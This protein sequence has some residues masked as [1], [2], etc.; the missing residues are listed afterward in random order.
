MNYPV[1]SF[2]AFLNAANGP[3]L[4]ADMFSGA[5]GISGGLGNDALNGFA[6]LDTLAGGK[7]DDSISGGTGNDVLVGDDGND[8]LDGGVGNDTMDGG[9]GA[10][11]MTGGAGDDLYGVDS[12]SDVVTELSGDGHDT[13][14]SSIDYELGTNLE[15]LVLLAGATLGTGNDTDNFILGNSGINGLFGGAGNDTLDGGAGM[16]LLVGG[17][18][19]DSYFVDQ[20]LDGVLEGAGGGI[21]TVSS[22]VTY[23]LGGNIENLALLGT[24]AINGNGN[25]LANLTIGN[26]GA[27]RLRGVG[28]ADTLDGGLGADT[29]T[30]GAGR[31]VFLRHGIGEGQDIVTDFTTG[32]S[33][34]LADISDMLIG[35][36]AGSSAIGDFVQ[37]LQSGGNTILQVDADGA[38]NGSSFTSVFELSGVTTTVND[39][40]ANGNLALA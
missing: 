26:D 33:G 31:D 16:D 32:G 14:Q 40:V 27:N 28:G 5:D 3:G 20:A 11:S 18:G 7:G 25:G 29:L 15:D 17:A 35:Y 1:T 2:L 6:G 22:L 39:L 21:D 19:N 12:K 24:A 8:T 34:D 23:T 9:A 30:G 4:I 13:V 36:V 38:A 37:T 10:D